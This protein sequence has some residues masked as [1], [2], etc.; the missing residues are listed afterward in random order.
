MEK[1]T[2]PTIDVGI[3]FEKEIYFTLLGEFRDS[4]DD[5]LT[6]EWKVWFE[7]GNIYLSNNLASF[8]IEEGFTLFPE[9]PETGSFTLN[10]VTIGINFHWERKGKSVV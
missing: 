1:I 9:N 4:R 5:L 8:Q 2:T 7:N 3:M 10:N 6:G